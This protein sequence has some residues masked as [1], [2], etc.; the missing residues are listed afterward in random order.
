MVQDLGSRVGGALTAR[1]RSFRFAFEGLGYVLATQANA[2]IHLALA[3]AVVIAGLTLGV[4][5]DDWRWLGAAIAAVW[6]AEILNTA[7]EHLC[8][9]VSPERR[10][11]VRRAKDCAAGAVLV[12]ALFAA[13]IGASV[14]GPLLPG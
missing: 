9:V 7:I 1:A 11:A 3:V 14:F 8:D 12:A 6:V 5:G 13:A 4:E 2:R 10:E